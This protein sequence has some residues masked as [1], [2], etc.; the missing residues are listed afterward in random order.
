[1][2]YNHQSVVEDTYFKSAGPSVSGVN[3]AFATDIATELATKI[4][5]AK[6][7]PKAIKHHKRLDHLREHLFGLDAILCPASY[8]GAGVP[9]PDAVSLSLRNQWVA[10]GTSTAH[11]E[12]VEAVQRI[13]S[14]P[15][16][17]LAGRDREWHIA[18]GPAI[19]VDRALKR[20]VM[21]FIS[22]RTAD[23]RTPVISDDIDRGRR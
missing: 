15:T 11:T 8:G 22:G 2:F 23:E 16:R 3:L 14:E 13:L 7:T 1:M 21:T 20:P 18:D 19:R 10:Q 9:P 12:E 6:A 4:I 5:A 17:L